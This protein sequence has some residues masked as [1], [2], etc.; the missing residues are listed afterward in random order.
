MKFKHGMSNTRVFKTWLRMID[1]CR[2][3][4]QGTYGGRNSSGDGDWW[5]HERFFDESE[6]THW[7][8]LPAPPAAQGEKS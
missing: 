5:W 3:D 1:R 4:R 2:N 8:P 6:V 7:R